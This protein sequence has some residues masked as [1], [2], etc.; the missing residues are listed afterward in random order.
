L[1][2]HIFEADQFFAITG[3]LSVHDS[4]R[5]R[6]IIGLSKIGSMTQRAHHAIDP[7]V[8]VGGDRVAL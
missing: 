8:R 3:G 6:P 2:L 4:A 1:R 7:S 5:N